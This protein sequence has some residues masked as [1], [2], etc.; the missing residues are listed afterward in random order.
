MNKRD[1]VSAYARALLTVCL[2]E[3]DAGRALDE[4]RTFELLVRQ[5]PSLGNALV[6][7]AVAADAKRRIVD[8]V[9]ARLTLQAPVRKMV[10][11]MAADGKFALLGDVARVYRT[12]L[13]EQQQKVA[14]EVTTAIPLSADRV[15]RL[16]ESLA[17]ATG[18]QVTVALK[19]DGTILGGVVA[20]VGSVIYDGSV[21][22]HLERIR[23]Q[24]RAG[25]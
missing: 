17:A 4:L 11:L 24:L 25:A 15:R 16:E 1:Q 13:Q 7:P 2:A 6:N 3:G 20:R 8:A 9:A 19:V 22:R 12:R 18:K 14:A 21:A 23:E 5:H 10:A